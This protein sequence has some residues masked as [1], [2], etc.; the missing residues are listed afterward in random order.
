MTVTKISTA[1]NS[2]NSQIE[3]TNNENLNKINSSGKLNILVD[4][5]GKKIIDLRNKKIRYS[6]VKICVKNLR[7]NIRF[8]RT[9]KDEGYG[10]L[11]TDEEKRFHKQIIL[12][13]SQQEI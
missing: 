5:L 11:V 1:N 12:K 4:F 2:T 7:R 9:P 6:D 10:R 8:K 13:L 3:L